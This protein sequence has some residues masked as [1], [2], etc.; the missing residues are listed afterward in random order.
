MAAEQNA[1]RYYS[2]LAELTDD[3]ELR[4][5]YRE[6]VEFESDHTDFLQKKVAAAR[7]TS[8]GSR[9]A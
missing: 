5:L 8:G 7:R 2:R 9:H 1:L 3:I 6:F 4:D